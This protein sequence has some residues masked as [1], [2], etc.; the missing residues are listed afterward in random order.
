MDPVSKLFVIIWQTRTLVIA[1]PIGCSVL[2]QDYLRLKQMTASLEFSWGPHECCSDS[3]LS[4]LR[5][6]RGEMIAP[7]DTCLIIPSEMLLC[8]P[9]ASLRLLWSTLL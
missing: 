8:A 9:R 3:F 2:L 1:R 5:E 7:E 6:D 4:L